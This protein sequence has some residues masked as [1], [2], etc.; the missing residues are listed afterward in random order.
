MVA[1]LLHSVVAVRCEEHILTI[2]DL[3]DMSRGD[4]CVFVV[5][6][7]DTDALALA[8]PDRWLLQNRPSGSRWCGGGCVVV[9][10]FRDIADADSWL[11]GRVSEVF[12]LGGVSCLCL[13]CLHTY[14]RSNPRDVLGVFRPMVD[15]VVVCGGT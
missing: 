7:L 11:R 3:F 12:I 9:D 15:W 5:G 10:C 13:G 14:Q 4:A 2:V 8:H 6:S 1:G